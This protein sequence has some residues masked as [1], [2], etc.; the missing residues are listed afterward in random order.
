VDKKTDNWLM[1]Q[2][3]DLI[4]AQEGVGAGIITVFVLL[5]W[6]LDAAFILQWGIFLF[7]FSFIYSSYLAYRNISQE[8]RK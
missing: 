1:S 8:N 3:D 7:L 5:K 2:I 6:D 4:K